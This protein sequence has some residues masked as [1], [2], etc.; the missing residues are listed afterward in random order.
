MV[1]DITNGIERLKDME[2]NKVNNA[3][4]NESG[5]EDSFSRRLGTSC[6]NSGTCRVTLVKNAMT[7]T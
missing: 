3:N 2:L 1:A 7:S 4:P 5:D 6:S